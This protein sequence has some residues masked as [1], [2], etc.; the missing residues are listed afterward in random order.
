MVTG[1]VSDCT[2]LLSGPVW[3]ASCP[4][5]SDPLTL[6]RFGPPAP[7]D[8]PTAAKN[9]VATPATATTETSFAIRELPISVLSV[10][11]SAPDE[12]R[13]SLENRGRRASPRRVQRLRLHQH[14]QHGL[15]L[16]LRLGP[17]AVGIGA[18]DYPG[19]GHEACRAPFEL[20]AAQSN[21]PLAVAVRIHPP[22]RSGVATAVERL[23]VVQHRQREVLRS[24]A[25]GRRRVEPQG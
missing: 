17:L 23:E 13:Q 10:R 18:G 14:P 5:S 15:E 1:T 8:P 9:V 24:A 20:G 19:P 4:S 22:D 7:A 3:D 16:G 25:D 2:M 11:G 12:R 6:P 21:R